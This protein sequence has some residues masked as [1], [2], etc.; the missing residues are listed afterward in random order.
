[1]NKFS[2]LIIL[3]LFPS[4]ILAQQPGMKSTTVA[5]F[6]N[7]GS[8]S[9]DSFNIVMTKSLTI[10]LSKITTNISPYN[11]VEKIAAGSGFWGKKTL[12][13]NLALNIA[14]RFTSEQVI[15]GDYIINDKDSTI[16]INVSVFNVIT[17]QLL[18]QRRYTGDSGPDIFDTVDRMI[19]DISGL[20]AGRPI[21]LGYADIRIKAADRN[22][23]LYID[24]KFV[25]L[26]NSKEG[27]FDEFISGQPIEIVLKTEVSNLEV[28]RKTLDVLG[29]RTNYLVY[30]P[31]GTLIIEAMEKDID[32]YINGAYIGKTDDSGASGP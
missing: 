18:F 29:G 28:F 4:V 16:T 22:Y 21:V 13:P 5:G 11:E 8:S 26:I 30:N 25:K 7:R 9:Q 1:M 20:L 17:G 31:T 14:Q 3:F 27:F 32:V 2:L 10:F 15:T 19:L 23:N 12:N 24:D 6:I